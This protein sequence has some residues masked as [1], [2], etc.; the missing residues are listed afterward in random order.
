MKRWS[1]FPRNGWYSAD[2]HLH[3]GRY[4]EGDDEGVA[5]WM[6]AEDLNVAN[7]LQMGS[8]HQFEVT[9]QY[10]FGE[11]GVYRAGDTLLISGQEHPRTHF[12]GH[13]IVL[14]AE[15][16]IDLRETYVVYQNFWKWPNSW[17]V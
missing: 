16:A 17:V 9:P 6:Q 7:L 15:K 4:S 5:N 12:L 2:D 8:Y 13:T 3:I 14:G 1:N 11:E 10:A